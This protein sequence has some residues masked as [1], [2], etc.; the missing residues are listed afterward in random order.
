MFNTETHNEKIFNKKVWKKIE[1]K[2]L[3]HKLPLEL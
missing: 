1:N 3:S 2:Y